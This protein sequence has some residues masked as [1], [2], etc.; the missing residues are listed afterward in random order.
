MYLPQHHSRSPEWRAGFVV[1]LAGLG[2]PCPY[3][4]RTVQAIEWDDGWKVAQQTLREL[5]DA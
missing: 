4:P 5:C 2:D 3:A 1:Y